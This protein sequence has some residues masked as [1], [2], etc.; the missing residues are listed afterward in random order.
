MH[1]DSIFGFRPTT[2]CFQ[3][4]I[5]TLRQRCRG[6]VIYFE[7]KLYDCA[8][9]ILRRV[10]SLENIITCTTN[11]KLNTHKMSKVPVVWHVY[12]LY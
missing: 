10:I 1:Y 3:Y 11:K 12:I 4:I 2:F 7:Q 5:M 9:L 8:V 6:F